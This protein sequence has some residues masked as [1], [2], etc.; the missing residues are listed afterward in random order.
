MSS[1]LNAAQESDVVADDINVD[2]DDVVN[3]N[4][5]GEDDDVDDSTN[6]SAV[7]VKSMKMRLLELEA[8]TA[9]SAMIRRRR[10]VEMEVGMITKDYQ[11]MCCSEDDVAAGRECREEGLGMFYGEEDL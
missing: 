6:D 5:D 9:A 4:D 1:L 10:Q 11:L 7:E 8:T 2:D 3:R